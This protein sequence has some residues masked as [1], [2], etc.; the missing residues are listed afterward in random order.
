MLLALRDDDDNKFS[1]GLWQGYVSL[2]AVRRKTTLFM[3]Q[4]LGPN[5]LFGVSFLLSTYH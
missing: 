2:V 1:F 4:H 3:G 5:I